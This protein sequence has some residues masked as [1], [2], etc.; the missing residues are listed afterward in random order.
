MEDRLAHQNRSLQEQP[1]GAGILIP[2]FRGIGLDVFVKLLQRDSKCGCQCPCLFRGG[3]KSVRIP[4]SKAAG[5]M[6]GNVDDGGKARVVGFC[7]FEDG[8][9]IENHEGYLLGESPPERC[10]STR[11][12]ISASPKPSLPSNN[13]RR[14]L[15]TRCSN[16][17]RAIPHMNTYSKDDALV[18]ALARLLPR[19]PNQIKRKTFS[20]KLKDMIVFN[21]CS[22]RNGD[23]YEWHCSGCPEDPRH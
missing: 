19:S 7:V 11:L 17:A 2:Q 18:Q 22:N 10:M 20:E 23:K 1:R 4:H 16:H 9:M 6:T 3:G 12:P 21:E 13:T 15:V 8:I 14:L 5:N